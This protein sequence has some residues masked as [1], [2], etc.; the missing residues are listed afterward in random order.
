M[1]S[2]SPFSAADV[3]GFSGSRGVGAVAAAS[4]FFASVL[5]ALSVDEV[6]SCFFAVEESAA[7]G[8]D[9]LSASA[10]FAFAWRSSDSA[11]AAAC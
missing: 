1:S 9:F 5:G 8:V 11:W 6:W 3:L 2:S 7:F 10:D 4:A